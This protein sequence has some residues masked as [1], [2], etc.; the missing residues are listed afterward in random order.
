MQPQR[1][2]LLI[3][4][5]PRNLKVA[6]TRAAFN[7]QRSHMLIDFHTHYFPDNIGPRVIKE[8]TASATEPV[9]S[10]GD[11]T[12]R[13]L[14]EYMRLDGVDISVNAPPATK[15]EQV[16]SINRKMIEQNKTGDGSVICLGSMHPDFYEIGNVDEELGFLAS[17]GI[18]GI[19]LHPEYQ[20]FY[21]DDPEHWEIYEACKKYGLFILFH[22]GVDLAYPEVHATPKRLAEV[23]TIEGLKL[24]FAHMGSYR[25]WDDVLKYLCG[26][27]FYFDTAY[28]AGAD[29]GIIREL[30]KAH[31]ADKILFGSD[32][33][34][35][36][37]AAIKKKFSGLFSGE[38]LDK[39]YFRNAQK[40]LG[41]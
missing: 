32:F 4:M 34:W 8:L 19:K 22:A 24:I 5:P 41:V 12:L 36:R 30:V 37:A 14:K 27:N 17:Q 29:D 16:I 25:M 20:Q 7:N 28:T 39:I 31:G 11:G 23:A 38:T 6:V 26:G 18:K 1:L 35:E 15:K 9:M 21:P 13:S 3:L 40:L 2:R 33:P 10:C